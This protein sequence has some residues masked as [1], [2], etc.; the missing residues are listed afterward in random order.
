MKRR[1]FL[2]S[3]ASLIGGAAIGEGFRPSTVRAADSPV[4][5]G[6]LIWGHSETTQNL[7]IHQ[8]GTASTLRLLQN[9][10]NSIVTVD[11]NL[12][13][14]P[15]LAKSFEQSAN[16]LTYS[17]HLR[18]GVKFHDG[19]AMTSKDVKYSFE[20]CKNKDT[21]AVNFEVFN[22]VAAIETPDDLTV[23]MKMN[24]VNAPFLSRLAENGA[25]AIMP[26][27][28]G[29][30]QGKAPIGA[31]PFKFVRREF[32]HEVELVRFDD[33]WDGPAYLDKIISREVTEPTVRLTGL[34]TGEMHVINDIPADRIKEV[35]G[36]PKFQVLTWFPLNFD[37]VNLNHDFEPFKDARVRMAIDLAIDK[38]ALL[39]G[40]LWGEGKTTASPS[41]PTSSS[42]NSALQQ[43]PQDLAKAKA[44]L[45]EAG[46]PAGKLEVVFKAT[47]NYP[48]HVESAQIML[49]WFKEAGINMKIEQLTWADWLSQVWVNKD[50][51]IS[52]MNFF[53]LWEPDFLYYSLWNSTGAFNYRK[54]KDPMIDDLTQKARVTVEP[55]ARADIYKQV[56]QRIY[57][58]DH[59]ILLWFRNGSIG[60]QPSVGGIDTIVHPNGSNLNF[61]K[62]WLR[63]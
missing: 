32:G 39:Q 31:G 29:D 13:V 22:D 15:S 54:I 11:K 25:G 19:K 21:G 57:D 4:Q 36:D 50:F 8:T 56:Q 28:S 26:E 58:Q 35:K 10:H 9:V 16:G 27:G 37:F 42:Y 53:T 45:A 14:I 49:E 12:T 63:A 18:P 52:M 17:F 6:T 1:D 43:R 46:Y 41:Y 20:R 61:H 59:D 40:A 2:K 44:L 33:Y 30:A 7:D 24:R 60:A 38:E 47:T 51:Q 55:A 23:I 34:R 3:T 5:G 48:Y 62:V